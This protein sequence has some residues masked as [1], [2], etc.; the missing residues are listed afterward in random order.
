MGYYLPTL[1][2]QS[3]GLSSAYA[4]LLTAA[5]ATLYLGAALLCL[6]LIDSVG[7]RRYVMLPILTRGY[8]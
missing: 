5:N 3:V 1:L 2:I 7:R 8:R 4:R 6:L